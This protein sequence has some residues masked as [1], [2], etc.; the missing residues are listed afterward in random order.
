MN[1]RVYYAANFEQQQRIRTLS[2]FLQRHGLESVSTWL[3]V[4]KRA[5]EKRVRDRVLAAEVD[6]LDV[7]RAD[8]LILFTNDGRTSRGGRE[9]ELGIALAAKKEVWLVGPRLSTFHYH[10]LIRR[11][12]DCIAELMLTVHGVRCKLK[13]LSH[14]IHSSASTN[15]LR[16]IRE[17]HFACIPRKPFLSVPMPTARKKTRG[18]AT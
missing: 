7:L 6:T 11:R 1:K 15:F 10:P 14:T 18:G 5:L 4:G 8:V 16:G 13:S 9:T 2:R 3:T 12:F 17:Q